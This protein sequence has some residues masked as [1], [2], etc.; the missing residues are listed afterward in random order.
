M[1]KYTDA[2][3]PEKINDLIGNDGELSEEGKKVI[4]ESGVAP[5]EEEIS[6]IAKAAIEADKDV[7]AQIKIEYN[8]ISGKTRFTFPQYVY[9]IKI[10]ISSGPTLDYY[11]FYD[12]SWGYTYV[13]RAPGD[14]TKYRLL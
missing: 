5:S 8:E 1:N 6:E 3:Y 12:S 4:E 11:L 13:Q 7:I 10:S 14:T 2:R 9:P